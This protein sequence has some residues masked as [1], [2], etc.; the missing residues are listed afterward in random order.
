M[1]STACTSYQHDS[2]GNTSSFNIKSNV[3]TFAR[4]GNYVYCKQMTNDCQLGH[5]IQLDYCAIH[6]PN[7]DW[8][9][10][11]QDRRRRRF[12]GLSQRDLGGQDFEA[13][14]SLQT[15]ATPCAWDRSF[16]LCWS[17]CQH[18][19]TSRCRGLSPTFHVVVVFLV[20]E[21]IRR[22]PAAPMIP[23]IL[24]K[25]Y[26]CSGVHSFRLLWH[27]FRCYCPMAGGL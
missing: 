6:Q 11:D 7:S 22:N 14:N 27:V 13:E 1:P 3:W 9:V 8:A 2:G 21:E 17:L 10:M 12:S 19:G 25:H 24:L 4:P 20:M 26:E 18:P 15:R 16:W 5:C 23:M